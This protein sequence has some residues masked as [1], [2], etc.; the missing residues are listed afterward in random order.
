MILAARSPHIFTIPAAANFLPILFRALVDGSL[1]PDFATR[2]PI[3]LSRATIYLPTRRAC[4]IAREAFLAALECDTAILPRIVPLGD[5][6]EDE[7]VFLD[8]AGSSG[9]LELKPAIGSFERRLLLTQLILAWAGAPGVATGS[10]APLVAHSPAAGLAL[11]DD[12][13]RLIDDM[14]TRQVPWKE[15]DK[16]VPSEFDRFWDQTLQFL[17]IAREAWPAMLAE[18]GRIDLAAHRDLLIKKET[19]RLQQHDGPVIVAGS[20]GS[21]PA[22]AELISVI[23]KLPQGAI[24]LPG[25]DLDLD[26]DSWRL[27]AGSKDA[28]PL[29][30]H[31]QYAMQAL[32][33]RLHVARG[34]VCILGAAEAPSRALLVS[35]ALRPAESTDRWHERLSNPERASRIS[36]ALDGLSVIEAAHADEEALAI[37]VA[38]REALEEPGKTAALVTPDRTLARRVVA[39]LE[40]WKIIAEDTGGDPLNATPAGTLARL[41]ATVAL[42]GLP[43]VQLLALLKHPCLRLA[44]EPGGWQ[45]A[46]AALERAVLRGS[47]PRPGS[48]GLAHAL[49]TTRTEWEKL[50]RKEVSEIFYGDSRASLTATQFNE[51]ATLVAALADALVPLEQL[52]SRQKVGFAEIATAH[53]AVLLALNGECFAGD[54]GEALAELF[55]DI[56]A[57]PDDADLSVTIGDYTEAFEAAAAPRIVRK[58]APH[59]GRVRIYGLLEARLTHADRVVLGGLV[60]GAWPPETRNDAWLNRPMRH[61]LGLD[62]PER[63]V[64]LAA[65]DFAQ[66]LGARE[67]ILTHAA[68]LNGTPTIPSRFVQ[69][70]AAVAGDRWNDV[71]AR[72]DIYLT[73]ARALERPDHPAKPIERPAPRPP[74]AARPSSLS[75]TEIETWLRDPYSIYAKHILRLRPLEA[76]DEPPGAR[77]RGTMIHRAVGE[78]S[79]VHKDALPPDVT[80]A[81]IAYGEKYFEPLK[82]HPE[83][84]A[85]WWP[86]FL[87]V[88]R[89]FAD[90]EAGRRTNLLKLDAEISG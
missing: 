90:F 3:A 50:Q 15:L 51:A 87:R 80:A 67:V 12:L 13:A 63:R 81:L 89:W 69:R 47:R 44:R 62:L 36:A 29:A 5:I 61:Q 34:D 39:A 2:D 33:A 16:L 1:I 72:G 58:A 20:T 65:H 28:A 66:L 6:D 31:P 35:E 59:D 11:A 83:A 23:A 68:K 73:M 21:M 85:F 45:K 52:R 60:E 64:G 4:R 56:T 42:G 22:T 49:A 9:A 30:G 88:A 7:F 10:G 84:R 41:A 74:R 46:V 70:L 17:R 71:I 55:A 27:L 54:D 32:L 75:V 37:A 79:E 25:L 26:E 8:V 53:E 43:P 19:E 82:D 77:D 86:R 78:F 24:V 14:T 76:V 18:R 40:R 38:L 48:S 57:I